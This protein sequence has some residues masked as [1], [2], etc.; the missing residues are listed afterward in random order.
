LKFEQKI[1]VIGGKGMKKSLLVIAVVIIMLLMISATVTAIV[2]PVKNPQGKPF[3]EVWGAIMDLQNQIS[4]QLG[5]GGVTFVPCYYQGVNWHYAND[6]PGPYGHC[7]FTCPQGQYIWASS[8]GS[9]TGMYG[10]R[11]FVE[12]R[13][14][15]I[16]SEKRPDLVP[17][18]LGYYEW[19]ECAPNNYI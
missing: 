6:I 4:Q 2:T 11:Y 10:V 12:P 3:Q 17:N 7:E 9:V 18:T 19:V 5:N 15:T 8:W 14:G 13:N 1:V 16:N